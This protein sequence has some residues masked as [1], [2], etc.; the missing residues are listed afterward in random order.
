MIFSPAPLRSGHAFEFE[1]LHLL[2]AAP[3]R[4][5]GLRIWRNLNHVRRPDIAS[6][7]TVSRLRA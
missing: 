2:L 1:N 7:T 6:S 4:R 3:E 5:R